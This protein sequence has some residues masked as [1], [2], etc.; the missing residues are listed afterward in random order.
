MELSACVEVGAWHSAQP[1]HVPR[2]GEVTPRERKST[3]LTPLDETAS[4][5]GVALPAEQHRI[6]WRRTPSQMR[7]PSLQNHP[8]ASPAEGCIVEALGA[9]G[10]PGRRRH[11]VKSER[12]R[13]GATIRYGRWGL[14]NAEQLC[15]R[16]ASPADSRAAQ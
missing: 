7:T 10:P 16:P 11:G 13:A 15:G 4:E 8:W 1:E 6:E 14:Q 3:A 9:H 5:R 2:Q 12:A